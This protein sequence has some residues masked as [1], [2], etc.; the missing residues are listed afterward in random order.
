MRKNLLRVLIPSDFLIKA[1]RI[2]PDKLYLKLMYKRII[3]E[4]LNINHPKNF[5]E[6]LQ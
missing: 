4:K 5:N 2:I 1:S 3:G 6:K